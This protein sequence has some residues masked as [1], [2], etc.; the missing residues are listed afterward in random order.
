MTARA[1]VLR[2]LV[3]PFEKPGTTDQGLVSYKPGSL[4]W[5]ED[6][7]RVKLLR[8]HDQRG[9]V[10]GHAVEL[11][12]TAA[13]IVG[14]FQVADT[15]AGA[16]ALAEARAG[17]RDGLSPGVWHDVATRRKLTRTDVVVGRGELR[18]VSLVCVPAWDDARVVF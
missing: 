2:G 3:V 15:D 11:T 18:E 6:V 13:G 14:V 12:E 8:E 1:R 16:A 17:L 5:A 10:L 9:E 7:S 4:T